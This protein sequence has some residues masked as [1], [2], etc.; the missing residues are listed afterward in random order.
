MTVVALSL[1]LWIGSVFLLA[2]LPKLFASAEFE[3][4]VVNYELLPQSAARATARALPWLELACSLGLLAGVAVPVSSSVAALLLT[5]FAI[6]VTVNLSRGRKIECGCSGSV[7]P[8]KI[9]WPLVVRDVAVAGAA[10]YLATL[11]VTAAL[12]SWPSQL[13]REPSA[14]AAIAACCIAVTAAVVDSGVLE[15]GQAMWLAARLRRNW[16]MS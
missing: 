7:A 1:R 11:P 2:A 4:A 5:S 13:T 10:A 15:V 8:R 16:G 6:A 12:I 3:R 14:S 9:S